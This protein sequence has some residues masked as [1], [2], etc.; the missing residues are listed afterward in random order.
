MRDPMDE[1][2]RIARR[3]N[4][5]FFRAAEERKVVPAGK[6]KEI[7]D[8]E[9]SGELS[10]KRAEIARKAAELRQEK[11]DHRKQKKV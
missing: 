2:E 11:V 5:R 10:T 1:V 6:Y 3:I 7:L 8:G 9:T 4:R